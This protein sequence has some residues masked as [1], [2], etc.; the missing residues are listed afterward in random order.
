MRGCLQELP[1]DRHLA[2]V[3]RFT[4]V[5][6]TSSKQRILIEVLNTDSG[7]TVQDLEFLRRMS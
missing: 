2:L 1:E 4:A 5:A 6:S 3:H 7:W